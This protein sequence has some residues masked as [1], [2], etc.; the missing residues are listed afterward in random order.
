[1]KFQIDKQTL[2]AQIST[3]QRAI[4][5]RTNM[6]ILEGLHISAKDNQL[7]LKATDTEISIQSVVS[8]M[9]AEE[10]S[11]VIN[12]SLLGDIVRKL[13]N[14]MVHFE[15]KN[16]KVH[17]QCQQSDFMIMGQN[18]EDFPDLP[19]VEEDQKMSLSSQSFLEALKQTHFAVSTDDLRMTLTGVLMDIKKDQVHFVALDGY[20]MAICQVKENFAF[21]KEIILP[22]RAVSELIKLL[23]DEEEVLP[24][25]IT[26]N[27]LMIKIGET[28][29]YTKLLS[30][31]YFKYQGLLRSDHE[32]SVQIG[33][34]ALLGAL[35]RASLMTDK[36][37]SG[38]IK[39]D[40]Q[41]NEMVIESNSE[42]GN[43]HEVI[44]CKLQGH[45]LRI[46]FNAR[47]L[48]EGIRVIDE[49]E[50]ELYFK[51]PVNPCIIQAKEDKDYL[52]LVLPV[53]LAG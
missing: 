16:N 7:I 47:Y 35:E 41:E 15:V 40:I 14:A 49:E 48:I 43:V 9:V 45:P 34:K 13:P 50:I 46:A 26:S 30:G 53:R 12:A 10:G 39:M 24:I 21:E 31:Q 32:L 1:M 17:I 29:F 22:S 25:A 5:N 2:S 18:S 38:L 3:V 33:A 37:K 11:L 23:P 4:S 36:G 42:I 20:R 52:Y 44:P 6:E 19:Q 27:H 28:S 51:D 8:A